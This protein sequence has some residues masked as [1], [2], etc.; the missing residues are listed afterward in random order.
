MTV[1]Q[2]RLIIRRI[3]ILFYSV[4]F[5]LEDYH[6]PLDLLLPPWGKVG[7]GVW[8]YQLPTYSASEEGT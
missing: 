2:D 3:S 4:I 6:F 5:G 7:I 8:M 1:V